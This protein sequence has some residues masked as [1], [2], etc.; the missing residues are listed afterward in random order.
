LISTLI[1]I[2]SCRIL[3]IYSISEI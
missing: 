3:W 2:Y 1:W